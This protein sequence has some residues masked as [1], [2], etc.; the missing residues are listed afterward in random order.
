MVVTAG[1]DVL[2]VV[3]ETAGRLPWLVTPAVVEEDAC[4]VATTVDTPP[5]MTLSVLLPARLLLAVVET[6]LEVVL[7]LEVE[8]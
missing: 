7:D 4:V 3:E 8:E 5:P 2:A 1:T 6:V